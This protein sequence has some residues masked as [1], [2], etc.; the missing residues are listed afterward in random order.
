MPNFR[1]ALYKDMEE[2]ARKNGD[3]ERAD[4]L[5]IKALESEAMDYKIAFLLMVALSAA[6][7]AAMYF[8]PV[9]K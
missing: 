7:C 1:T 2:I 9:C 5:K 8:A 3:T 6:L 4:R